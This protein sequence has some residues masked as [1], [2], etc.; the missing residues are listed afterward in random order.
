ML[1]SKVLAETLCIIEVRE[2]KAVCRMGATI[3]MWKEPADSGNHPD[4]LKI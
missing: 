4:K 1:G 2:E 3:K